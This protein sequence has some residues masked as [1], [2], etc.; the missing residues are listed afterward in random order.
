MV[1]NRSHLS[2]CSVLSNS[3]WPHGLFPAKF[4]HPLNFPGKNTGVGCYSL[5]QGL[6]PTIDQTWVSCISCIGR[7]I[8]YHECQLETPH[9]SLVQASQVAQIQKNAPANS[10]ATR[11]IDSV[12]G[13]GRSPGGG[14]GNPLQC[15]CLENSMDRGAWQVTVH[16]IAVKQD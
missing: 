6:F 11:D 2:L 1:F 7:Q 5:L 12:P 14:N 9:S 3:S 15:S 10:G 16:E 4:L 8:L 13:L